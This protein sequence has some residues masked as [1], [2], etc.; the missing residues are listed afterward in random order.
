MSDWLESRIPPGR[1]TLLGIVVATLRIMSLVLVIYGGL[2]LMMLLR[3]IEIPLF[4]AQRPVTPF[5]TQSV[6]K[7]T[8]MIF[9]LRLRLSG[10]PI[11]GHTSRVCNHVSWMDVFVLNAASRSYFVAKSEVSG[12]LVIGLLAR[13]TGTVFITRKPQEV[14]AQKNM[15]EQRLNLGHDLTF[16]PE[17][18]STDGMRVLPFKSALFA[19]FLTEKFK[20]SSKLQPISLRYQAPTGQDPR[21]YG[22]WGDMSFVQH[23][24]RLLATPRGGDVY[25]TYHEALCATDFFSRKDLAQACH[26]KVLAGLH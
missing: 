5:I 14:N 9:G 20:P 16:F 12:W 17:G 18:T 19:A 24:L 22:W 8:L 4:G 26:A 23:F 25:L 10:R 21:L 3:V 6:C 15:L 13:A 11:S 2:V 1:V 7:L